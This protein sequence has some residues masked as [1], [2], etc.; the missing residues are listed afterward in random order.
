VW[1]FQ[2]KNNFT[3]L[4]FI[5]LVVLSSG[6]PLTFLSY[7]ARGMLATGFSLASFLSILPHSFL[8]AELI[9]VVVINK[10]EFL[11]PDP[12]KQA[13]YYAGIWL[14]ILALAAI[15]QKYYSNI[16]VE[17]EFWWAGLSVALVSSSVAI[18]LVRSNQKNHSLGL[19]LV[20]PTNL[21]IVLKK[22]ISNTFHLLYS[23]IGQLVLTI[24]S[25]LEGRGGIL[26]AIVILALLLTILRV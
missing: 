3:T 25:L 21:T 4:L 23:L 18:F 7:G 2:L 17:F 22:R 6:L 19:T 20:E 1:F 5:F 24:S 10:R 14:Q 8:L 13:G 26:W 15:S 11:E 9:R 12:W 16:T